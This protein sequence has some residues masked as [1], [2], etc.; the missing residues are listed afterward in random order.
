MSVEIRNGVL[1]GL[2]MGSL[3]AVFGA[4]IWWEHALIGFAAALIV[5]CLNRIVFSRLRRWKDAI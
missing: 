5:I 2:I 3:S 4:R 1:V